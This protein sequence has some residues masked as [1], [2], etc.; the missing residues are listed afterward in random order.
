LF[1]FN[2]FFLKVYASY[3][4]QAVYQTFF[5]TCPD[6]RMNL[7]DNFKEFVASTI[8]E[9]ISAAQATPESYKQWKI[10]ADSTMLTS[11]EKA[12]SNDSSYLNSK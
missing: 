12:S 9:W 6:S 2:L 11:E 7:T 5:D 10:R 4:A 3:L 8:T 1:Y